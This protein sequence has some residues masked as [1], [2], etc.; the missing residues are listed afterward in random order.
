VDLNRNF[1]CKWQPKSTWQS[2]TVDAGKAPFSE[3]EAQAL[4]TVVNENLKDGTLLAAVFWHSAAN[5][6]YASECQRG[7]LPETRTIMN[8][9]ALAAGYNTSE[10]FDSYAV[11]GAAEDW[12]ASWGVPAIT[13]EL[14][15]HETV[16]WDKNLRGIQALL[17]YAATVKGFK[18][19]NTLEER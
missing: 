2:K 14:K 8:A 11:T 7:V 5:T 3:P 6:V 18:M 12:L 19:P 9:Y 16:E 1:D 4:R 15:S 13:V 10:T 17:K